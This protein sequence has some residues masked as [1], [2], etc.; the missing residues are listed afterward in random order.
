M[1][2]WTPEPQ[3]VS[4]AL[5]AMRRTQGTRRGEKTQLAQGLVKVT[6]QRGSCCWGVASGLQISP[7]PAWRARRGLRRHRRA[8]CV[9]AAT[10]P[11]DGCAAGMRNGRVLDALR[12][13]CPGGRSA[14]CAS[15]PLRMCPGFRDG[16]RGAVLD[17]ST[18]S[19]SG[20]A[21]VPPGRPSGERG[22]ILPV[23][24]LGGCSESRARS[25]AAGPGFGD[26]NPPGFSARNAGKARN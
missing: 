1:I 15:Q 3:S 26:G 10:Q 17:S 6:R 14:G 19:R 25:Y 16:L 11:R 22:S 2:A 20:K 8:A 23:R 9:E 24:P 5:R 21:L 13:G 18:G 4:A 12:P 7:R